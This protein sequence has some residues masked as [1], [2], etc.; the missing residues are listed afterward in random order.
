AQFD[1][2]SYT[3]AVSEATAQKLPVQ[4]FKQQ[5]SLMET[6]VSAAK[7]PK[8]YTAVSARILTLNQ[9]LALLKTTSSQLTI[10]NNTIKQMKLASLDTTAMQMQYQSDQQQLVSAQA[11]PTFQ[12]LSTVINAQ[13]LQAVISTNLALPYVVNAKL[14]DI[15]S[16]VQFLKTY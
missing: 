7:Y 8:D 3:E 10:F 11:V 12:K 15:S 13:Y 16:K 4:Y 14:S 2:H 1:V 6:A 9:G 5:D